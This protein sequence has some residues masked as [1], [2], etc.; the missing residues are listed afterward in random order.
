MGPYRRS[1]LSASEMAGFLTALLQAALLLCRRER[2]QGMAVRDSGR[3]AN[4]QISTPKTVTG[5]LGCNSMY[6]GLDFTVLVNF[7]QSRKTKIQK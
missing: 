3:E 2:E 6:F 1:V 4:R 7:Q 5:Q